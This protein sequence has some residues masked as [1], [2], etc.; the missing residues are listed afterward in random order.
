MRVLLDL[1]VLLDVVQNREGLYPGSARLL[2]RVAVGEIEGCLAG[3]ALTT[4]FYL[5][6]RYAT[7]GQAKELVDWL[8]RTVEI[9]PQGRAEILRARSLPMT[10]FED[11]ATASAAEATA[12]EA[13]ATRN[14][15]DF[16]GSPVP[17]MTPE[18]LLAQLGSEG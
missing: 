17:A 1:N 9:A 13:I 18:E 6:A 5:V 8:L 16:V 3:H 15:T 7:R 2:S 14:L 12:C 11:A 4:L 10:D